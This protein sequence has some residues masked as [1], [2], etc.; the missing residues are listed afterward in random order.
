[1]RESPGRWKSRRRMGPHFCHQHDKV[2]EDGK[3][4]SA[5]KPTAVWVH[6]GKE[7]IRQCRVLEATRL[8]FDAHLS[9]LNPRLSTGPSSRFRAFIYGGGC[10]VTAVLQAVCAGPAL[11]RFIR[12]SQPPKLHWQHRV[13]TAR[14]R[15]IAPFARELMCKKPMRPDPPHD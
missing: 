2:P 14:F 4:V 5:S 10:G 15:D 1:M 13:T 6:R 7:S 3:T 12:C 11:G 8:L 9:G